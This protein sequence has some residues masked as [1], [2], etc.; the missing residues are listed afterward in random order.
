MK[1]AKAI[2]ILGFY[3]REVNIDPPFHF[4][5]AL[6]LSVEG[7][8]RLQDGRE[9]GYDYFDLLLPGETKK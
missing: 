6:R 1:L 2:E 4:N 8:K 7:L 3:Y 9:K 5:D